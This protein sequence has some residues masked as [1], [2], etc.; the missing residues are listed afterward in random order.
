[1]FIIFSEFLTSQESSPC[2]SAH[3]HSQRQPSALF[4]ADQSLLGRESQNT[5]KLFF[6]CA[7]SPDLRQTQDGSPGDL[8]SISPTQIYPTRASVQGLFCYGGSGSPSPSI[9]LM[10]PQTKGRWG[11]GHRGRDRAALPTIACKGECGPA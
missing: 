3:R 5:T 2:P 8:S 7:F 9:S 4:I 11:L 10:N 6:S 1:M